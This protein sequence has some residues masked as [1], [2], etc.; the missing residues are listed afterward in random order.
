MAGYNGGMRILDRERR[1][2]KRRLIS[3]IA[4]Q[5][6]GFGPRCPATQKKLTHRSSVLIKVHSW[7]PYFVVVDGYAYDCAVAD[8]TVRALTKGTVFRVEVIDGR[9]L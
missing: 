2:L 5:Y 1:A 8:G 3:H 6:T 7:K 4:E 9:N